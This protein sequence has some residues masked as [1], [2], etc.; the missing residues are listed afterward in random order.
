MA[1]ITYFVVQPFRLVDCEILPGEPIEK[2]SADSARFSA[3][4]IGSNEGE[5]AV[6]FSRSGDPSLG[7][8]DDAIIIGRWG[9]VPDEFAHGP[10]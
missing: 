1:P 3:R 7:D 9:V 4:L 8:I 5:G 2:R 6:A 10:T